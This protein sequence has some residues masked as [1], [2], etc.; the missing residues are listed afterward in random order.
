MRIVTFNVNGIRSTCDYYKQEMISFNSMLRNVLKTDI[1]CIQEHK[2]NVRQKLGHEVLSPEDYDAYFAFPKRPRVHGYSGTATFVKRGLN[3]KVLCFEYG[4]T[5]IYEESD[6]IIEPSSL[7]ELKSTFT[8]EQ[9]E[10]LDG[11]A[12]CFIIDF[13]S[14]ILINVYCPVL[15]DG[16]NDERYD[17]RIQFLRAL[18]MRS[19]GFLK[20]GRSVI[21]TGDINATSEPWDHVDYVDGYQ[22]WK[23]LNPDYQRKVADFIKT[24]P[25][26]QSFMIS[27]SNSIS[28]KADVDVSDAVDNSEAVT[29][30]IKQFYS[31]PGRLWLRRLLTEDGFADAYRICNPDA[32]HGYTNW[33]QRTYSRQTNYGTRIDTFLVGGALFSDPRIVTGCD[34]MFKVMGSDHCPVYLDLNDSLLPLINLNE[35]T[36]KRKMTEPRQSRL[37]EFFKKE[38]KN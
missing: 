30:A 25:E 35:P 32:L 4:L 1:L 31:D 27:P 10:V 28:H 36:K 22:K 37:K 33:D 7:Q 15:N 6:H 23:S 5:G 9:L 14:F 2:T 18:R 21:L 24:L 26:I 8:K 29:S 34:R 3:L 38:P 20:A 19:I 13:Q 12:R 16:T 11:E 17:F